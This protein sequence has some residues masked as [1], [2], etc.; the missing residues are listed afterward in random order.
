[1]LVLCLT[2]NRVEDNDDLEDKGP[3]DLEDKI[4]LRFLVAQI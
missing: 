1:M 4:I 3:D 2:N